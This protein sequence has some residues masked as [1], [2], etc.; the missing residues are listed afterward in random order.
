M[1]RNFFLIFLRGVRRNKAYAALNVGGLAL[2][3]AAFGII[4]A[5][6][7]QEYGYDRQHAA[8]ERIYRVESLFYKGGVKTDDWATS[9]SGY[10]PA[11]RESFPEIESFARINWDN[12]TRVVRHGAV[13]F[14][15]PRVCFADSNFFTFFAYPVVQ[16]DPRTFLSE[17]NT[18]VLSR[19]AA[20]KYFGAADPLGQYL[21]VSTINTAYRC[22][23]TGVFADLPETSTMQFDLLLS[24]NTSPPRLRSYWYQHGSYTFVRLRPGTDP[25][26]LEA[27]F[28]A[29]AERY[30]TEEALKDHTWAV[31]LV[32]LHDIHLNPAKPHEVEAKGNRGAVHFLLG[33]GVVI[34]LMAWT[35]YVNLATARAAER[36]REAGIRKVAGSSK[37]LLVGQFL[38]ESL[39]FNASAL[40]LA[41]GL[42]WAAVKGLLPQ[43]DLRILP[44]AFSGWPAYVL[45]PVLLAVGT[46]LA[47]LY[48]A[49]VL[50]GVAP[51]AVLKGRHGFAPGG[52]RLRQGLVVLQ[53]AASLVLIAGTLTVYRQLG[54]MLGGNPGVQTS[55]VLVLQAPAKT[56][57]YHRKVENLKEELRSLPGVTAVTGSGAV[58]GKE[59]AKFLANR[60]LHEGPGHDRL[61]EMLAA[62]YDFIPAYGLQLVAG[63]NFDRARPT[64]VYGLV[65]NETAARQFGFRTPE[66]AIGEK[67]LLETS[68]GRPSEIIGVIKDYH[69]QSLEQP[70]KPTILFMDPDLRWI[71]AD[72][73]SLRLST[74][75][76]PRVVEGVSRAWN[77]FF[78]ESSLDYFFLDQFYDQQYR[79]DRR[80]G[81]TFLAF[82]ALAVGVACLGLLGLTYYST[83]RRVRE[84]GIRKVLGATAA[85]IAARLAWDTLKWVGVAAVPA[86][87]VAWYVMRQWLAGYAFR[88]GLH[89]GH[90]LLPAV[91]LAGMALL[92]VGYLTLRAARTNPADALRNE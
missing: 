63:R 13:K 91:A 49:L 35:N 12:S 40:V 69:Q 80:F 17:P 77:G 32:P 27:R 10:A 53:F 30:K 18:V 43:L 46:A 56:E 78:P 41:G 82:S 67:V 92:T 21:D 90:L 4:L 83:A 42:G 85:G 51:V 76:V 8:G 16:G 2:G 11:M 72:Y 25:D 61:Y 65:L 45:P 37:R 57:D 44:A 1:L 66:E 39:L 64:D 58:P 34:L 9:T 28:P 62:D 20:R 52:G 81:R 68:P 71:P 89:P 29:L 24:W 19:R 36:A 38:F 74:A 7:R 87:P 6:V 88:V 47:G 86:M 54:Y 22:R 73:L 3:M 48:P 60:R 84:I 15:E 23:V 33:L 59:V 5:Y 70:Y 75:D 31:D 50:A 55:Q 26:R 79:Q 14:R